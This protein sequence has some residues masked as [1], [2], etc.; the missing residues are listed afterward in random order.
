MNKR[1]FIFAILVSAVLTAA[2]PAMAVPTMQSYIV[3]ST[4]MNKVGFP[5]PPSM[6]QYS[7]ITYNSN[8]TYR[9]V[10]FWSPGDG[11]DP[12]PPVYDE[13]SVYVVIGVP[14]GQTGSISINGTPITGFSSSDPAIGVAD[15]P[16]SFYNH[17]L[18]DSSDYQMVYL[19]QINNSA[20]EAYSYDRGAIGLEPTF[21][22]EIDVR[23]E[24]RGYE[25]VHFDAVG[26][27][28][29]D[30]L[31]YVNPY[32]HDASYHAPEPGTLS[33]LGVGLLGLVPILRRKKR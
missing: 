16:E 20:K 27:G 10:G 5:F 26:V 11:I 19:G 30:N 12:P 13:M 24:V 7:W 4:Y 17:E 9:A 8:F 32:S 2:A 1:F 21:G 6:E 29:Y 28:V 14:K 23:V 22:G 25:W 18:M 3:G 31:T 15:V 33:L